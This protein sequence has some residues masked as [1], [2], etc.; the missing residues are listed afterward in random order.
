MRFANR[1]THALGHGSIE[2]EHLLLGILRDGTALT[3]TVLG[4]IDRDF[5]AIRVELFKHMRGPTTNVAMC[6][7]PMGHG[8]EAVLE[9]AK[10]H[11]ANAKSDTI[12]PEHIL[13]ALITTP[14]TAACAT[15]SAL[16]ITVDDILADMVKS[17]Q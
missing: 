11:A 10:I 2:P 9:N 4:K 16:D 12:I 15:L 5:N 8:A 17:Q 1:E 14:N 13:L 3:E 7:L 6:A